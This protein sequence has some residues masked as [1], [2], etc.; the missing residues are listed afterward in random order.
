[1]SFLHGYVHCERGGCNEATTAGADTLGVERGALDLN[2][3][4]R[5][6]QI[7]VTGALRKN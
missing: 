6:A 3:T 7:G 1:M 2:T 5:T 4:K